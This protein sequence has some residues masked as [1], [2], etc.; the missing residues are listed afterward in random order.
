M[1]CKHNWYPV[2][3]YA[4]EERNTNLVN[5]IIGL[6]NIRLKIDWICKKCGAVEVTHANEVP[7]KI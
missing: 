6:P 7:K 1:K 5:V 3:M 2:A 4:V